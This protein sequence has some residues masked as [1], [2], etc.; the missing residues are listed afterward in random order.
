MALAVPRAALTSLGNSTRG[1]WFIVRV[2]PVRGLTVPGLTEPGRRARI[3][4]VHTH[5]VS[6]RLSYGRAASG[7]WAAF[8]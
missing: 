1:K 6:S 7:A 8:S 5:A 4:F 2:W 3:Q